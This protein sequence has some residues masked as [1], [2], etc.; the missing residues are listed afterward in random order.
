MSSNNSDR[1]LDSLGSEYG[2][3]FLYGSSNS[4]SDDSDADEGEGLNLPLMVNDIIYIN[5]EREEHYGRFGVVLSKTISHVTGAFLDSDGGDFC[6]ARGSAVIYGHE[7]QPTDREI[8]Y[9][10]GSEWLV[11][12]Y[13]DLYDLFEPATLLA[14]QQIGAS[15][16][17]HIW[18]NLIS[19]F[20]HGRIRMFHMIHVAGVLENGIEEGNIQYA[21]M[22]QD[23]NNSRNERTTQNE[24][25]DDNV[26]E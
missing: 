5:D 21:A 25:V 26:Q 12:A 16:T 13:P 11:F 18:M 19:N 23:I 4:G 3:N 8:D 14:A 10:V 24:N 20:V 1:S 9:A 7:S 22:V 15:N 17:A 2:R 6:I